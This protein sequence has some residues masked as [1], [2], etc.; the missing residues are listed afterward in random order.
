M[1]KLI[2]WLLDKLFCRHS[3]YVYERGWKQGYE[4]GH[5]VGVLQQRVCN[6]KE[7]INE[8]YSDRH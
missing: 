8:Y 1:F 3:N 4:E 7:R 2:Y 5:C 6:L